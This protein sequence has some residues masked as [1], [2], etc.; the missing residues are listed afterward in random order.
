MCIYTIYI[1]CIY[2][3]VCIIYVLY[4]IYY[5]NYLVYIIYVCGHVYIYVDEGILDWLTQSE[6]E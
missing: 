2:Y 6:A 1:A 5:M 3:T 4:I